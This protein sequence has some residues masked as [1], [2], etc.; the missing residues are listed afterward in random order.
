[1]DCP[2]GPVN[3]SLV[4]LSAAVDA[5][6]PV[7]GLSSDA[8]G[9]GTTFHHGSAYG[10]IVRHFG[11]GGGSGDGASGTGNCS[12]GGRRAGD[13]GGDPEI[14][15]DPRTDGGVGGGGDGGEPWRVVLMAVGCGLI[16]AGTVLGNV[17][18]CIAVAMVRKL[19]TPSNLLIVSLA[20][21]CSAPVSSVLLTSKLALRRRICIKHS[22]VFKVM[23]SFWCMTFDHIIVNIMFHFRSAVSSRS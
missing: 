8:S 21:L 6:G 22:I 7:A 12:A 10:G 15:D 14:A 17:L 9:G 3:I 1:M 11:N 5:V 23:A 4:L 18:V 19:R 20:G 16:I 2:Y 13:G